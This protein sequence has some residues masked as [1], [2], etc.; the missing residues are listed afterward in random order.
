MNPVIVI[1]ALVTALIGSGGFGAYLG[2][3]RTALA[4]ELNAATSKPHEQMNAETEMF[5]A[6]MAEARIEHAE[7]LARL[8]ACEA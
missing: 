5:K 2:A 7:L 6:F 8:A 4:A 3:R 1:A